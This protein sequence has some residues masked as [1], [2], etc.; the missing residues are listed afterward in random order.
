MINPAQELPKADRRVLL[1]SRLLSPKPTWNSFQRALWGFH[2]SLEDYMS[3]WN[4]NTI[5]QNAVYSFYFRRS[6]PRTQSTL[7]VSEGFGVSGVP[8][9][10]PLRK[11]TPCIL[12]SVLFGSDIGILQEVQ[13]LLASSRAQTFPDTP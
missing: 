8:C 11:T 5:P 6:S 7:S 2:V 10:D 9:F 1:I 12:R 3:E 13:E 4:T